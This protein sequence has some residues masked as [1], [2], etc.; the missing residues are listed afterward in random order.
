MTNPA[1][2]F[3]Q[4]LVREGKYRDYVIYFGGLLTV[5]YTIQEA[6]DKAAKDFGWEFNE[7]RRSDET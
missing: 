2:T 5:G 1:Q 6:R 3:E 4:R 7:I